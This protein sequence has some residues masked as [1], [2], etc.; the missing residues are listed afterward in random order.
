VPSQGVEALV[1]S[2]NTTASKSFSTQNFSN[3]VIED[4]VTGVYKTTN[5]LS[6]LRIFE[7]VESFL[8]FEKK[9]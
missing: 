5:T 6:Y 1:N 9:T 2:L 7:A 8:F 3:W 4:E